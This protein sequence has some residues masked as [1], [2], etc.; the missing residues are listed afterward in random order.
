MNFTLRHLAHPR[1]VNHMTACAALL[2][3]AAAL[4]PLHDA[5]AQTLNARR[6]G[7]GGAVLPG[8]GGEG[9]N[10]AYRAVPLPPQSSTGLP[11]PIGL[12]QLAADPPILD[13]QDPDFN[14]YD[15]ANRVYNPPWNWQL[16]SPAPPSD[17]IVVQLSRDRLTVELGEIAGLFPHDRSV[18]SAVGMGPS[19]SVG[20]GTFYVGVSAVAQYQNDLLMNRALHEAVIGHAAF[21]PRTQYLLYDGALGQAAG[22]LE[23]GWAAPVIRSADA[24][25]RRGTALFAGVRPKVLRGLAYGYT[26]NIVAFSTEDTLITGSPINLD[27]HGLIRQTGPAGGGWGHGLDVGLVYMQDA[28]ELGLGVNDVVSRMTWSVEESLTQRDT[29][30]GDFTRLVVDPTATV[31]SRMPIAGTLNAAWRTAYLLIAA[32]TERSMGHTTGHLGTET[33]LGNVALRAGTSIDVNDMVQF[34]GGL[35]LRLGR[36]GLDLGIASNSRN[37]SRERGIELGAGLALYH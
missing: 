33:W 2:C 12:V 4:A 5:S 17:D 32:D 15:L 7:M 18:L 9:W 27:Y 14:I 3:L 36:V 1:S 8:G 23:A 29:L 28:F 16:V 10:A 37:L 11:L 34:G 31:V 35:G 19:L 13:P 26:E 20:V 21:E 6:M 24:P 22:V 30:A 25:M